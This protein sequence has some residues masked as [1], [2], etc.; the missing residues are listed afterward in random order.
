[1]PEEAAP[2]RPAFELGTDGPSVVVVGFDGSPPSVRAGAYAAGVAR[3][4]RAR[5][6]VVHVETPPVMALLSPDQP[7]PIQETMAQRTADLRTQVEDDAAHAGVRAEFVA[8]RG[9]PA[10]GL[11]RLATQLRADLVVV[12]ASARVGHRL[13]GSLGNRLVRSGRWPVVVVP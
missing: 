9:E 8:V 4:E 10:A 1:M 13:L 3:R 6:V 7:W 2:Q 11:C 12:G 5:L